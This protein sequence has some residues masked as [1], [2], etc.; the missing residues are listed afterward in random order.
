M[1]QIGWQI[2]LRRCTGCKGCTV[3]CI[4]ENATEPTVHFRDVIT[5]DSG[6]FPNYRRL[7]VSMSCN[8]CAEPACL[9]S[10][11]V[12]A[13]EKRPAD[14]P[15]A[16]GAVLINQDTCVGCRH[17]ETVCPYRAPRFNKTTQKM[18]KCTMCIHRLQQGWRPACETTCVGKAIRAFIPGDADLPET[19]DVNGPV[20]E[21][22]ANPHYTHPSIRFVML[23]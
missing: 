8:H 9:K 1:A 19:Y 21:D 2:D 13:I 3:A 23:P 7:F 4:M 20:P 10:C 5:R 14:D 17:C 22:F 16:P 18:L 15:V 11:P 12:G 6:V